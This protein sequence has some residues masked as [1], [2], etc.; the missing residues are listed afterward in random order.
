MGKKVN[1]EWR[2]GVVGVVLPQS[3][4]RTAPGWFEWLLPDSRSPGGDYSV[5]A[6][7]GFTM[8]RSGRLNPIWVA[9]FA[10]VLEVGDVPRRPDGDDGRF[11]GRL[12]LW[13]EGGG[14]GVAGGGKAGV[15][16]SG[17]EMFLC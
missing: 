14:S 9:R 1:G 7:L 11:A 6:W 12:A 2:A 15:L 13:S 10:S 8:L 5:A 3:G 17:W 4:A 16:L